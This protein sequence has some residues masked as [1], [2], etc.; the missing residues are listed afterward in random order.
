MKILLLTDVPPCPQFTGGLMLTSLVK[1]FSIDQL[2]LC[3]VIN[4]ALK[5]EIPSELDEI[6]KLLLKKPRELS[7]RITPRFLG[8]ISAYICEL[9]QGWYVKYKLLPQIAAFAQQ[10]KV[11]AIWIVLQGQTMIRLARRLA[12]ALSIPLFTQIYDPFELWLRAN[13]IDTFTQ[14]RLLAEFDKVIAYSTACMT[15]SWAMSEAYTKKY[16]VKNAPLIP[17]LSKELAY[18]PASEL[19]SREKIMIGMA[20]QLYAS[21]E[22]HCLINTLNEKKWMIANRPVQIRLLSGE[23]CLFTDKP[24]HIEYFGWQSQNDTIRLLSECDLLYLP[25]WFSEEFRAETTYCFPSKLV[26][27]FATGRPVFCHAP[28]YASPYQYLLKNEAGY[29]CDSTQ[30]EDIYKMLECVV[31]DSDRYAKIAKNG[32]AC[33]LRDFTI[34]QMRES[35]LECLGNTYASSHKS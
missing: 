28:S 9:F 3:A 18:P 4:P 33:F 5:P 14:H 24:V 21:A 10:E 1:F 25:Y 6:S 35:F 16:G 2:A 32:S 15:A 23:L 7:V 34:E 13:R 26:T 19:H 11:S 8:N 29:L 17:A 20:G 27:Y 22:W 30:Q 12:Q 31:L